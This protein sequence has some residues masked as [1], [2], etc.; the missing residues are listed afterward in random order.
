MKVRTPLG[1][2]ERFKIGKRCGWHQP[3]RASGLRHPKSE[4]KKGKTMILHPDFLL[5]QV[6]DRQRELIAEADRERLF[7]AL[8][9]RPSEKES[10]SRGRLPVTST[11]ARHA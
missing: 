10:T 6:H 9:R 2:W 5:G 1:R 3:L 7:Q 4:A 8:R 11:R